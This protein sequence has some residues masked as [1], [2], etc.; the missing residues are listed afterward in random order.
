MKK[1][2]IFFFFFF[3]V[4]NMKSQNLSR[5]KWL[6]VSLDDLETGKSKQPSSKMH[7]TLHFDSDTSYSGAYCNHYQGNYKSS[8]EYKLNMVA[9]QSIKR[10]CL[11]IGER[12]KELFAMYAKATRY[13]TDKGFLFIFTSDKHRL[14]FTKE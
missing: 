4:F 14:T 2:H 5:I 3:F 12:E 1:R 11:G 10:S 9:P 7:A 13:R 8:A 6:L